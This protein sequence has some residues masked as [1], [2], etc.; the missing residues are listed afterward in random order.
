MKTTPL[1][2]GSPIALA[3]ETL[4]RLLRR[5][6]L[7]ARLPVPIMIFA[8]LMLVVSNVYLFHNA[9]L[10]L[11]LCIIFAVFIAG[12]VAARRQLRDIRPEIDSADKT[13]AI[14][15]QAGQTPDLAALQK[16]LREEAPQGEIRDLI[17]GWLDLGLQGRTEGFDTLLEEAVE[18]RSIENGRTLS[19]HTTLNRTTLKLGFLG[20]LIGIILTFPPM[21]RAVL[22]LSESEGELKFIRDIALAID[23]DQYAILSTL[24]ATGLSILFEFVT[25]QILERLFLGL[26]LVQSRVNEWQVK[27][28]QP[29]L[30]TLRDEVRLADDAERN[31]S[32]LEKALIEAQLTL[33]NHLVELAAASR[34]ANHQLGEV[35][36]VQLLMEERMARLVEYERQYRDFVAAKSGAVAPEG[37][38]GVG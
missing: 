24:I 20:T 29:G 37:A 12:Q 17:L 11:F 2:Q 22:G 36:R 6:R 13:L 15:E 16:R 26:D 35:A 9:F 19:L 14:L 8:T 38:Q 5:A 28:L 1:P 10:A 25:I 4:D 33:E 32:R 27:T 18:R 3:R 23:G 7:G 34:A 31:R 21:K 30:L